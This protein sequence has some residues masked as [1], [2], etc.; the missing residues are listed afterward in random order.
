MLLIACS[1]I[2][3][4]LLVRGT[5]RARDLAIRTA[6]GARRSDLIRYALAE[7][8]VLGAAGTL[9]GLLG[10]AGVLSGLIAL[11]PAELSSGLTIHIDAYVVWFTVGLGL[12]SVLLFGLAPA[13]HIA[14]LGSS[15]DQLKQ[16]GRSDTEGRS[17]HKL[18]AALV[19]SQVALAL[20]LLA[21]A[22]LFAK[23]LAKV[24]R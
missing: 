20:V 14:T 4:L 24:R 15:Y 6:F 2:A 13:W 7:S 10:A 23:S 17:R 22:G 1:N 8:F 9:I 3:G 16:G 5:G 12:L 11:A 21:G 19:M 18:R